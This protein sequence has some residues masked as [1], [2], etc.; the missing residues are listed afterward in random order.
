[1]SE[2]KI[3]R[4][5]NRHGGPCTLLGP[6]IGKMRHAI[7][8]TCVNSRRAQVPKRVIHLEP[9]RNCPDHPTSRYPHLNGGHGGNGG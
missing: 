8:Y 9:C 1:M 3:A 6:V 7:I 5:A 4:Y 2:E